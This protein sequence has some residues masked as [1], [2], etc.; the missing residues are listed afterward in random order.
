MTRKLHFIVGFQTFLCCCGQEGKRSGPG[1]CCFDQLITALAKKV[2]PGL[3][4]T[5]FSF[6]LIFPPHLC[7]LT[8][9]QLVS[10]SLPF[11]S[12]PL[13]PQPFHPSVLPNMSAS[14][15]YRPS[16]PC[17]STIVRNEEQRRLSPCSWLNWATEKEMESIL[18]N[19]RD[20]RKG[21]LVNHHMVYKLNK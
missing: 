13:N 5:S 2:P 9:A 3:R 21:V 19:E 11:C 12:S 16:L 4:R 14:P 15:P 17:K 8:T 20:E 7:R 1:V 10:V 18:F 6:S